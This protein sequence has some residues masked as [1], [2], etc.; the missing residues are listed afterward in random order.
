MLDE[1]RNHKYHID[2]EGLLFFLRD[3]IGHGQIKIHDAG[4]ICS[5]APGKRYLFVEDLISYCLSF[6]WIQLNGDVMSV[7]SSLEEIIDDKEKLN[8]RLITSSVDM[9]FSDGIID[10][11]MFS[12]DSRNGCYEFKNELLSLS[13]SSVRNVLISQ[14][15]LIPSRDFQN[16]RFHISPAYE[17]LIA[18]HCRAKRRLLSLEKLK[19]QIENNELAGEMA[20][21]YVL[22]Y[23]K[24]RLGITDETKVKRISEIDVAAG[25]DIVSINTA[26]AVIPN[27]FIEVKTK[28]R[29]GFFW[30]KNE[31]EV[32]KL[33]GINYY[34]YL[35]DLTMIN[36]ENYSPEIIN[37]PAQQIMENIQWLVEP[38][39]YHIKKIDY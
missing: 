30:S 20:E 11:T 14:R 36:S 25:Y 15:F 23:E 9:L 6:E 12:Y 34:L 7:S 26:D 2:K 8:E 10:S 24:R 27:R 28:S 21:L 33:L 32:A 38:Q 16:V 22:E 31:Y 18:K 4:I 37:N 13:L 39:S 35:V 19:K 29:D 17:P 5:H 3:V 1:L